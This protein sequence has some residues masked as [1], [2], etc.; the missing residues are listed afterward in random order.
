VCHGLMN[1]F[2]LALFV[3]RLVELSAWA[4]ATRWCGAALS[5]TLVADA[6]A[7][8]APRAL[9]GQAERLFAAAGVTVI[10]VVAVAVSCTR[11]RRTHRYG[12]VSGNDHAAGP[13]RQTLTHSPGLTA[14][15]LS[16]GMH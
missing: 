11:R 9:P 12:R 5:L 14:D 15:R 16:K 6:D 3:T 2:L 10:V 4:L 7:A 1:L 13:R 8:A